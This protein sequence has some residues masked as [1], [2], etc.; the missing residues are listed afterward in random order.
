LLQG[1]QGIII[2]G[3]RLRST[4]KK[5]SAAEAQSFLPYS[6]A[7]NKRLFGRVVPLEKSKT[8]KESICLIRQPYKETIIRGKYSEEGEI[9]E[10]LQ[11][12]NGVPLNSRTRWSLV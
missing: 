3:K 8:R 7:I 12:G 5:P 4:T 9:R 10:K 2:Q 1:T 6:R 11:R